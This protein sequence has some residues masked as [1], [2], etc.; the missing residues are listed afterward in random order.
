MDLALPHLKTNIKQHSTELGAH[1]QE[2]PAGDML[3]TGTHWH[4]VL[5]WWHFVPTCQNFGHNK[6]LCFS[7][8]GA[9]NSDKLT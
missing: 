1:Q 9:L 2:V 3:A 6:D 4:F 8:V 7:I 5:T